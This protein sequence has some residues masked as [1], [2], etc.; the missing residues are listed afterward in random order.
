[1]KEKLYTLI[2]GLSVLC[3]ATGLTAIIV[4][5]ISLFIANPTSFI[6]WTI[7]GLI[8]LVS[9]YYIGKVFLN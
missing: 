3:F 6:P 1:M 8:I 4:F 2:V 7:L 5:L 9:S